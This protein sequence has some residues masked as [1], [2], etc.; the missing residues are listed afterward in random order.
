MRMFVVFVM[1][2]TFIGSAASVRAENMMLDLMDSHD[3]YRMLPQQGPLAEQFTSLLNSPPDPIRVTQKRAVRVALMLFG[4]EGTLENRALL[5]TFRKRMRELEVDYRLDVYSD[6]SL[7]GTDLTPYSKIVEAQPDYIII[8]Q[9][10]VIQRRFVE[11]FLRSGKSKVILYDFASPLTHWVNRPPLMYVGFDQEKAATM[12]ASYLNRQLPAGIDI[13]ALVLPDGYLG[14]Q[15]C[16]V[17]LDEMVRFDR[18]VSRI[19]VVAD[20]SDKAFDAVRVLLNERPTDFIFSCSQNISDGVVAA[21]QAHFSDRHVQTNAWGIPPDSVTNLSPHRV[22]VSVL[23]M[24]DDLAIAL[25]EA[26]K[27]DLEGRNR[28]NLY[29]ADTKLMPAELDVESVRLM[30][31]QAYHYSVQ[32]W[33]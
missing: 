7:R 19:Q 14:N 1:W 23:F 5:T 4:E 20:N 22:K 24:K 12:L 3:F 10:G 31:Q 6:T 17:F 26:I 21:L 16:D 8:T 25:A 18:P 30:V 13:S 11:R 27:L 33:P 29:V 28:P 32:L 15:R 9:F 2:L